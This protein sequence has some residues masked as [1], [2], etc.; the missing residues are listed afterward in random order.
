ML[1]SKQI[2]ESEI[3]QSK[4]GRLQKG[5]K[6]FVLTYHVIEPSGK[7]TQM[8]WIEAKFKQITGYND[9]ILLFEYEYEVSNRTRHKM[10]ITINTLDFLMGESLVL[11]PKEFYERKE[12]MNND[13]EKVIYEL[14]EKK[15]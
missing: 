6:Y 12:K 5:Q 3:Y 2:D 13:I 7:T 11:T 10:L 8:T 14:K 9:K 1:I 4:I 15:S